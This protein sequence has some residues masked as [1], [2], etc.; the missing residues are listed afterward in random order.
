MDPVAVPF[1][2]ALA[3]PLAAA[4]AADCVADELAAVAVVGEVAVHPVAAEPAEV[5]AVA[6]ELVPVAVHFAATNGVFPPP[7]MA[8]PEITGFGLQQQHR[9]APSYW[10]LHGPFGALYFL[11]LDAAH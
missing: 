6:T 5:D 10:I 3:S 4:H 8:P 1:E 9:A 7:Q 11:W 2:D